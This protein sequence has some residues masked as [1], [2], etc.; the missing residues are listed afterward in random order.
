MLVQ[1]IVLAIA[2]MAVYAFSRGRLHDLD[3]LKDLET[4]TQT[5][6]INSS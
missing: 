2:S 6:S 4:T 5:V 1:A 3:Q